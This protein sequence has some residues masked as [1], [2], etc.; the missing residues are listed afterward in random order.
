MEIKTGINGMLIKYLDSKGKIELSMPAVRY[1]NMQA[2]GRAIIINNAP[3]IGV[4]TPEE[5]KQLKTMNVD[6]QLT[7]TTEPRQP[8]TADDIIL[9]YMQ[10]F[11]RPATVPLDPIIIKKYIRQWAQDTKFISRRTYE[12]I[13]AK[14]IMQLA[15]RLKIEAVSKQTMWGA[16]RLIFCEIKPEGIPKTEEYMKEVRAVWIKE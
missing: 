11:A 3:F 15:P 6:V 1:K 13:L 16:K 14:R 7:F 5:R 9:E 2:D 8:Q 4:L 12:A 10:K